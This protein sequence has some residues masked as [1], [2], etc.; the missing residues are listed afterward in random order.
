M[1]YI[2]NY[3]ESLYGEIS[4]LNPKRYENDAK[5]N[6]IFYDIIEDFKMYNMDL[7]KVKIIDDE[8][9][10]NIF[11]GGI[12]IGINGSLTY[13]FGKYNPIHNNINSGNQKSGNRKIEI[14]YIPFNLIFKKNKL[15]KI[16]KTRHIMPQRINVKDTKIFDNPMY[17]PNI[18][19]KDDPNYKE[20]ESMKL[21]MDIDEFNIS[22]DIASK[23]LKYFIKEYNKQYP[24][25]KKYKGEME[26][27]DI[28]KGVEPIL[29]YIKIKNKDGDY[30]TYGLRY[31]ENE[32]EIRTFLYNMTNKEY[33]IFWK[34]RNKK[35]YKSHYDKMD[36]IKQ[37]LEIKIDKLFKDNDIFLNHSKWE[38]YGF[39]LSY[40]NYGIKITFKIEDC[41][42]DLLKQKLN[43]FNNLDKY[44]IEYMKITNSVNN[45]NICYI[46]ISLEKN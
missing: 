11:N 40:N 39:K 13:I 5:A 29:K 37:K 18:S 45:D 1:K 28:E 14:K 31:G 44:D 41:N 19:A 8:N 33:D 21:Y 46:S 38:K 35:L 6:N 26:I 16:F 32:K 25:L 23:L 7:K 2:K 22:V 20:G 34:N 3:N 36:R 27:S 4:R 24:K 15:E 30:L 10:F 42:K 12:E 17:N 9:N 43:F